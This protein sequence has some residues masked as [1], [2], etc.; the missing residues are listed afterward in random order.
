MVNGGLP[1]S[2]YLLSNSMFIHSNQF[3]AIKEI[4]DI[5]GDFFYA[6]YKDYFILFI[7]FVRV[8]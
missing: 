2:S 3:Q 6:S 1:D 8:D 4:L 5:K 7:M